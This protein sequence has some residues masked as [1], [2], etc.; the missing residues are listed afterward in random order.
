V[1]TL[2]K[3]SRNVEDLR[4]IWANLGKTG[5]SS[6]MFGVR[7]F[8]G[9]CEHTLSLDHSVRC[10]SRPNAPTSPKCDSRE[11]FIVEACKS[12]K[13][14]ENSAHSK[15]AVKSCFSFVNTSRE[16]AKSPPNVETRRSQTSRVRVRVRPGKLRIAEGLSKNH[17]TSRVLL[18]LTP[19]SNPN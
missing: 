6:E 12:K 19:S 14:L 10:W 1:K 13:V 9:G 18:S 15:T 7:T 5:E 4:Q 11:I 17:S 8:W 3:K 2:A 16:G